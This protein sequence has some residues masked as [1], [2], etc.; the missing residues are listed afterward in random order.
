MTTEQKIDQILQRVQRIEQQSRTKD[1]WVSAIWITR[2]T[3]WD[4]EVLRQARDQ[5]IIEYREKKG[6]G[7][8]YLLSSVPPEFRKIQEASGSHQLEIVKKTA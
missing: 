1:K 5:G 4:R 2:L 3:G 7:I 8:E 6:G